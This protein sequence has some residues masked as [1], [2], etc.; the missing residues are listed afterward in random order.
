MITF[1]WL[2]RVV[3][4]VGGGHRAHRSYDESEQTYFL[5][6]SAGARMSE[7]G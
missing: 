6:D 3:I 2:R 1:W 5:L 7:T 4:S